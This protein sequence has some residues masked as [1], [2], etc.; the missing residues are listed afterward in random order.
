VQ[1]APLVGVV[2]RP[3]DCGHQTGGVGKPPGEPHGAVG[4]AATFDQLHREV[5]LAGGFADFVDRDDVRVV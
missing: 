5:R 2:H 1:N 3:G 4:Q